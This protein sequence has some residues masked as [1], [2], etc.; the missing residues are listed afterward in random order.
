MV[1]DI[2]IFLTR[3]FPESNEKC[4]SLVFAFD[5]NSGDEDK[6][7]YATE[8]VWSSKDRPST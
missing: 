3:S 7:V 1:I 2:R 8:F 6:D 4:N 5:C